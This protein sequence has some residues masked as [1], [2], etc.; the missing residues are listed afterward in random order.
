MLANGIR[1]ERDRDVR[2]EPLARGMRLLL[3]TTDFESLKDSE[4]AREEIANTIDNFY[5][6]IIYSIWR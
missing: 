2:D 3:Q 1:S 5:L 4:R 6:L